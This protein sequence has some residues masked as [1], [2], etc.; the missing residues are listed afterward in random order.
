MACLQV[1]A[2]V[3]GGIV[4]QFVRSAPG[5]DGGMS[6]FD[7]SRLAVRLHGLAADRWRE[8]HGDAGLSP[9]ELVA[10]LPDALRSER[11]RCALRA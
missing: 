10:C 11:E 4:A 2:G 5:L 9:E 1:E 6:L 7:A 3:V 8:L